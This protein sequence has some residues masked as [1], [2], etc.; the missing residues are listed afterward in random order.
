M[1]KEAKDY[2]DTLWLLAQTFPE[3]GTITL[4]EAAKWYWRSKRTLQRD[5][6]FPVDHH[7]CVP[8]VALARWLAG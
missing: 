2:R 8:I 4:D 6:T 3:R 7:G 5:K 1:A